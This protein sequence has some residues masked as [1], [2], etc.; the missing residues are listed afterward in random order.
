MV[1][2]D[3]FQISKLSEHISQNKT[4]EIFC[5]VQ[6]RR[7]LWS[8]ILLLK[9]LLKMMC[10]LFKEI[11]VAS[12]DPNMGENPAAQHTQHG[13]T[14]HQLTLSKLCVYTSVCL[15]QLSQSPAVALKMFLVSLT[16][17]LFDSRF[18]CSLS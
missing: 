5:L 12:V 7:T 1:I 15:C 11:Y 10:C 17:G 13:S 18:V 8:L 2:N 3:P 14:L 4:E 16:T 9:L 6:I